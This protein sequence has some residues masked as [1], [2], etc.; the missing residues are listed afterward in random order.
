MGTRGVGYSMWLANRLFSVSYVLLISTF[1]DL[2]LLEY[3][4]FLPFIFLTLV[5]EFALVSSLIQLTQHFDLSINYYSDEFSYFQTPFL[6]LK[7]FRALSYFIVI[8]IV[9]FNGN[10]W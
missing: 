2:S 5:L 7:F 10:I 9:L 1:T 8:R 3:F 4:M 6:V